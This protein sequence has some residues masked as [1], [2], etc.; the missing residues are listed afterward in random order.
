MIAPIS[1]KMANEVRK[2]FIDTG[3]LDPNRVNTPNAKAISV[4]AGIAQ[5]L[6]AIAS[7]LLK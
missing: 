4:A 5:P 6:I 7:L 2:I 1:S 3:T